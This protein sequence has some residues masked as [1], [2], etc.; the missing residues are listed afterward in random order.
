[1]FEVPRSTLK[2]KVKSKETDI[3]ETD[4]YP[5]WSETSVALQSRR[6]TCQLLSD[7]GA[8]F[9]GL[10]RRSIKGLAFELDIK[11]VL[12]VHCQ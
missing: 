7:N 4:Q 1:M 12:P 9:F 11:M 10:I 5:T 3:K 6:R 8:K 2:N